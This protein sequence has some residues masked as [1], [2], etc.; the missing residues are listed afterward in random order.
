MGRIKSTMIKR[1][2]KKLINKGNKFSE[3]FESNKK[4]LKGL[5][6]SKGIRNKIAG[7]ITRLIRQQKAEKAKYDTNPISETTED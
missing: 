7:Y 5:M 1:T 3:D 6:P 2:S 4:L